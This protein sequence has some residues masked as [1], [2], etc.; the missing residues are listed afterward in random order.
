MATSFRI[1]PGYAYGH[2]TTIEEILEVA[3]S[4]N[5]DHVISKSI[6]YNCPL[7]D[8]EGVKLAEYV[9]C[10]REIPSKDS[11]CVVTEGNLFSVAS[12]GGKSR[13][14]KEIIRRAFFVLVTDEC[15]RRGL[16]VCLE[17]A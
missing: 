16:S 14:M 6:E 2:A 11:T 5:L 15:F 1:Y 7:V 9:A 13:E 4:I 17:I 10:Y 12:G 3:R 8:D